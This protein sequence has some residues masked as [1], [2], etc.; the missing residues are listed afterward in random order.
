MC[1]TCGPLGSSIRRRHTCL[2]QPRLG[3]VFPLFALVVQLLDPRLVAALRHLALLVEQVKDAELALDQVDAGLQ[4][5]FGKCKVSPTFM[6]SRGTNI[7]QMA[8]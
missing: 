4:N 1:K 2:T 3:E 6:S 7:Q 8:Y 5:V